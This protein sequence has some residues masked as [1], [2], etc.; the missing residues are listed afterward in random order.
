MSTDF[1]MVYFALHFSRWFLLLLIRK[2]AKELHPDK[3]PNAGDKFKEVSYAYE[4][5]SN[6]EKR[7]LYDRVGLQASW[8][9]KGAL[10]MVQNIQA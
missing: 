3:N 6:P 4:V 8:R 1:S 9:L 2:L 7:S 10:F 5:L